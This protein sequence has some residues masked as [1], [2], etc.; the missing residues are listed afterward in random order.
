MRPFNVKART[1]LVDRISAVP[2]AHEII[3]LQ[4]DP[5]SALRSE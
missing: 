4:P 1:R 2:G 3:G 5:L